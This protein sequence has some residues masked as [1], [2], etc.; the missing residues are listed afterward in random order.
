MSQQLIHEAVVRL[1]QCTHTS[2][3]SHAVALQDWLR[4][5]LR[6]LHQI[7]LLAALLSLNNHFLEAGR[8]YQV[9]ILHIDPN[10][11]FT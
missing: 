8:F 10:A 11:L 4:A 3:H 9:R 2:E 5:Q 6:L 7:L 1:K